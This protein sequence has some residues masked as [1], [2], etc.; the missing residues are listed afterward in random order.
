M[1][2][3]QNLPSGCPT[4][5]WRSA[6]L[7]KFH[8]TLWGDVTTVGTVERLAKWQTIIWLLKICC[9]LILTCCTNHIWPLS[10]SLLQ[11]Y[12]GRCSAN[13]VPLPHFNYMT[14][15]RVCNHC[16]LFQVT[17]FTVNEWK[18]TLQME[19]KCYQFSVKLLSHVTCS[20]V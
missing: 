3:L 4:I 19:L 20:D 7:V 9:T 2:Y 1:K 15:V 14:P 16:F 5:R 17:P 10:W 13:F 12:C 6:C 11:I 8:S 18:D